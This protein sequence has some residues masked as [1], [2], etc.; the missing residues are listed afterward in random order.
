METVRYSMSVI[1]IS[2]HSLRSSGSV[3]SS[4]LIARS[5]YGRNLTRPQ[6]VKRFLLGEM[7]EVTLT[8]WPAFC[9][10]TKPPVS[11]FTVSFLNPNLSINVSA[12]RT[13]VASAGQLQYRTSSGCFLSS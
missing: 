2:R 8:G 1:F 12:A 6:R 5:V 13:L 7:D 11:T 4:A 10:A 9:H 3:S